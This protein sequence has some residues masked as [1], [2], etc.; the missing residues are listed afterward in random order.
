MLAEKQAEQ[1]RRLLRV[2]YSISF[3]PVMQPDGVASSADVLQAAQPTVGE[4]WRGVLPRRIDVLPCGALLI[5]S[6]GSVVPFDGDAIVNAA[7]R[8]C[9]GGGGVDG[10]INDAGGERLYEARAMLPLVAPHVRCHT[11]DAKLTTG[12]D[13]AASYVIH[14]VGP[15]FRSYDDDD[16]ADALLASA[17]S[18]AM[19]RAAEATCLRG[20]AAGQRGLRYVAFS[21]ISASIFR[22][23]RPL[24]A[25][26]GIAV[27]TLR[28]HVYPGLRELHLVAF[29]PVE[30]RTLLSAAAAAAAAEAHA[31][32]DLA[33]A[34]ASEAAAD[35]R[36]GEPASE[37]AAPAPPDAAP[38]ALSEHADDAGEAPPPAQK[39]QCV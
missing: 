7:N 3:P 28:R 11:G 20:E 14:A 8:G 25:V 6:Q 5:C 38:P 29:T 19:A 13:L 10:A 22:G 16:E 23:H 18:S 21:L 31:G 37:A 33:A 34:P 9:L 36:A 32:T 4:A 27:N 30:L 26:L 17:Y 12:G 39:R 15:D 24:S 1:A 35:V 2:T